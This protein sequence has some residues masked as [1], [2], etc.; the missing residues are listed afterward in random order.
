LGIPYIS[1]FDMSPYKLSKV[2]SDS[3]L[4][5]GNN[6]GFPVLVHLKG[7]TIWGLVLYFK[8]II[9]FNWVSTTFSSFLWNSFKL[10]SAIKV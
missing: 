3:V 6:V 7:I 4:V 10:S 1:W 9:S 8:G 2:T 5:R